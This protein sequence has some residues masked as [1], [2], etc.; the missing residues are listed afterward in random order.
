MESAIIG[1]HQKQAVQSA[2]VR[3]EKASAAMILLH[4]RGSAASAI[5][6][7]VEEFQSDSFT[8]L[9]PQAAENSWYPYTFLEPIQLNQSWISSGFS[10][11][12]SLCKQLNEEN[13]PDERIILLGF[14][15]GACLALEYAAQ[16]AGRYGGIVGL[17][18][19]LIGPPG[20]P[21]TYPGSMD[22]T[23]V[24]L[25]CSDTDFH[26]PRERVLE[27]AEVFLKLGAKV[28][29]RLYPQMGH[30]INQDEIGFIQE[31]MQGLNPPDKL[32]R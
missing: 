16:H 12:A 20:T 9:A 8:Y 30:T 17:S 7:L 25:G 11:I 19:G 3:P 29:T 23:Q 10:V 2:G 5:L 14:S 22:N 32:S 4:G 28:T 31:M 1:P 18:G 24:F 13:I 26:I 21:R 15:Q 27:T 6:L